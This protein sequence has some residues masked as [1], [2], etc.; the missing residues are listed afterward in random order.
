MKEALCTAIIG[1]GVI[2]G[3]AREMVLYTSHDRIFSDPVIVKFEKEKGIRVKRVFDTEATKTAGLANR[4]IL[5]KDHPKAD[6]FW[7][8]EIVRTI[9]LKKKG[10]LEKYI[11]ASAVD[12]PS[13]FKDSEG[14]W[15]GFAARA[16][17]LILNTDRLKESE[18]PHSIFDLTKPEWKGK[19]CIANPLFGTTSTHCAALFVVLGEARAMDYFSKLMANRVAVLAGNATTKDRVSAG[20][21]YAGF[22]D[23]DDGN[24]A[25]LQ[26]QPVKIVF[27]DQDSLGTLLIP[28]TVAL[29]KGCQ[30]P[31]E[32]KEFIDFILSPEIEAD[33][34]ASSA[35]QIPLRM[36]IKQAEG[37]P[38]IAKLKIMEI[39][40]KK[41]ASVIENSSRKL[42][43]ILLQ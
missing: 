24:E 2:V 25:L 7:N 19:I 13:Q 41:A 42:E 9:I 43:K 6:V 3:N 29:I 1:F 22:T 31:S 37:I 12:I 38:P 20:I 21:Y 17:V 18:Y 33:L 34:A 16:R 23:T 28:N 27:P 8:N 10:C 36:G 26:K 40:F 11:S 4:L 32:A 15:A 35:V 30:H 5:E 39:D 14:F